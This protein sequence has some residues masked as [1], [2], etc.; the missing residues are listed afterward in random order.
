MAKV[1]IT[2]REFCK[3][4]EKLEKAYNDI[5]KIESVGFSF[6]GDD[7]AFSL[8]DSTVELLER[9]INDNSAYPA[10]SSFCWENNFGESPLY[11]YFE[12]D[13]E[14]KELSASTPSELYDFILA[15][16]GMEELV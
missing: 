8:I 10:I 3:V 15:G 14:Q 2:R 6:D 13:G 1:R 16:N 7:F 5:K 11:E 4:M 9:L 12:V